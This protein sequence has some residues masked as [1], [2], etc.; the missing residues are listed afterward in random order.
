MEDEEIDVKLE[1]N[2]NGGFDVFVGGNNLME[3]ELTCQSC[4]EQYELFSLLDKK[5][6][7][8]FRVRWSSFTCEFPDVGGELVYE[9]DVDEGGWS[10][11]FNSHE[12][13]I[14]EL[15]KAIKEIIK[16]LRKPEEERS[17]IIDL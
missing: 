17:M 13:R 3:L 15:T 16:K 14:E 6:K 2:K 5:I 12:Q 1:C 7:G 8:Y 4:P 9:S 11:N 10:G